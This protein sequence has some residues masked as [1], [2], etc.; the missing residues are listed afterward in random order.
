MEREERI[1][2]ATTTML[3]RIEYT[4]DEFNLTLA[5]LVGILEIAKHNYLKNGFE[6]TTNKG[7]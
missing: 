3:D 1:E 2:K 5:E 4:L 6:D 7:E